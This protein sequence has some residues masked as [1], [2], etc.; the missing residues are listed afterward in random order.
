MTRAL[1]ALFA[2]FVFATPAAADDYIPD[3]VVVIDLST[4]GWVTTTTANVFVMVDAAADDTKAATLRAEMQ[5][6]VGDVSKG[7]WRLTSFNRSQDSTGLSRWQATYEARIAEANL[8]GINDRAK[9]VS[10]PGMQLSVVNMDFTPTLAETEAKRAELRT[11][12]YKRAQEELARV[13]A[14]NPGRAYR[15]N[16]INF[17]SGGFMPPRPMPMMYA[18]AARAEMMAADAGIAGGGGSAEVAQRLTMTAQ[19]TYGTRPA[20]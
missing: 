13:N 20:K 16:S 5:K 1:L 10:K 17:S 12:L 2:F 15:I 7:D 18:K 9:K 19:V 14:A 4:E 3:D 11:E 6:A 8:A